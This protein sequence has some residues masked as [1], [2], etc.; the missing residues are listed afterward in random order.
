MFLNF[1]TY[2]LKTRFQRLLTPVRDWVIRREYSANQIT[3]IS[4]GLCIG[5][6]ILLL[7]QNASNTMLLFLPVFLFVRMALNALDGMVASETGTQS[8]IGAV[9][10]EVCDVVSDLA[11]FGAFTLLVPSP[12]WLWWALIILGMLSEFIALAIFQAMGS[13]PFSGPF[14]KSDRALY[15][16][17]MALLLM[18]FP[19]ENMLIITYIV[20]GIV[21]SVM[22]SWARVRLVL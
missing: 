21:L 9:L 15:L 14:G 20:F 5:Y 2:T 13:R 6:S 16:G 10:N 18:V 8:A 17:V 7:W 11:L 19:K 12:V 1:S 4:C 22:T 3:L